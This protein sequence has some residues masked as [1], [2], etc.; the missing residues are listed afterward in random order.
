MCSNAVL[1][2]AAVAAAFHLS[3]LRYSANGNG[4]GYSL[5][6]YQHVLVQK[7]GSLIFYLQNRSE[8]L[9]P[10]YVCTRIYINFRY[11]IFII[12]IY[13]AVQVYAS[14]YIN[15]YIY[16]WYAFESF[17]HFGNTCFPIANVVIQQ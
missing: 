17:D 13:S 10:T 9:V 14:H 1:F 5:L 8:H 3:T 6:F 7:C 16:V 4:R 11:T 2:S 15:L 12:I